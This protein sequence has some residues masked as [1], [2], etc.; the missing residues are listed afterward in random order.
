MPPRVFIFTTNLYNI[1][2]SVIVQLVLQH[3]FYIGLHVDVNAIT[4]L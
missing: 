4:L 1:V 2:L 3:G